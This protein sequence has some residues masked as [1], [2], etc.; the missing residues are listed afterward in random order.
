MNTMLQQTAATLILC[1]PS[2][3]GMN[4][5]ATVELA[6]HMICWHCCIVSWKWGKLAVTVTESSC[7]AVVP[8]GR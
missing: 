2:A 5:F 4:V 6:K 1:V 3:T 7:I 8:A